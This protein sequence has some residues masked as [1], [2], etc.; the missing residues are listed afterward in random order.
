MN[1]HIHA[2]PR[3]HRTVA[4][5]ALSLGLSA[6]AQAQFNYLN[7]QGTVSSQ[8][9]AELTQ[10]N[11]PDKFG[12][13]YGYYTTGTHDIQERVSA[14]GDLGP[15]NMNITAS[16][17]FQGVSV[18]STASLQ[19]SLL[20]DEIR[21]NTSEQLQAINYV[22]ANSNQVNSARANISVSFRL[23]SATDVLVEQTMSLDNGAS[24]LSGNGWSLT[25][26]AGVIRSGKDV[27]GSE[28]L[29][30]A[31]GDY[32]MTAIGAV[33][34][35]SDGPFTTASLTSSIVVRAVPEASTWAMMGLGLVGMA[36][37]ARRRRPATLRAA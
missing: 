9:H 30:L 1:S 7:Q 28:I 5:I 29:S 25:G 6:T 33:G 16:A 37:G 10:P 24:L 12:M 23:S 22:G 36:L 34:R 26:P 4:F 15:L 13:S 18:T 27:I 32:T 11:P 2:S 31:A 21:V 3:C 14:P 8:A 20:P 19:S 17:S 35:F